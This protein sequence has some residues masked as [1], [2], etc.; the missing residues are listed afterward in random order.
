M[1]TPKR[2]KKYLHDQRMT[3]NRQ[4]EQLKRSTSN[5]TVLPVYPKVVANGSSIYILWDADRD[6]FWGDEESEII[7]KEVA[8]EMEL[9]LRAMAYIKNNLINNLNHIFEIILKE[10]ISP[11]IAKDALHEGYLSVLSIIVNFERLNNDKNLIDFY[12][13]K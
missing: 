4:D 8:C 1:T 3:I 5:F 13:N 12:E 9:E 7:A 6:E 11:R 2:F 10:G